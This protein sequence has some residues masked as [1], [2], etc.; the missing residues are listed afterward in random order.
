[1][2][3][4]QIIQISDCHLHADKHTELYGYDTYANLCQVLNY[5]DK[6]EQPD[7]L[8][9][10][11]DLSQDGTAGSYQHLVELIEQ[12]GIMSYVIPGNHDDQTQMRQ[13]LQGTRIRHDRLIT[14]DDYCFI[15]LDSTVP[16]KASG[17]FNQKELDFLEDT[18]K[19][20]EKNQV[21]IACHHHSLSCDSPLMD[22]MMIKNADTFNQL[23]AN[24]TNVKAVF[25]GH[26]HQELN[27]KYHHIDY[28]GCPATAMPFMPKMTTLSFDKKTP[29]YRK[30][31][32]SNG[33]A[34]RTQVHYLPTELVD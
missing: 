1:M 8:L 9:F 20:T 6:H 18:L 28:F 10:T 22:T 23:I 32:L 24:Y 12:T 3:A 13:H 34:L 14:L 26:I 11:G 21:L 16:G 29:G 4:T 31:I 2:S 25:F 19:T 15:L 27:K 5:I 33:S 30:I 17:Y 7:L